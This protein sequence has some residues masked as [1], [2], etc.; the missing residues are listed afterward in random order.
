MIHDR[1]SGLVFLAFCLAY[2][3]LAYD[4]A[5]F[6][7]SEYETFT[8]RTM[9]VGLAAAGS[10][11]SLLIVVL[12]SREMGEPVAMDRDGWLRAGAL[13]VLMVLYG[14]AITRL[15]FVA[16]TSLFLAAG[17]RL[18]GEW[19]WPLIVAIS[20]LVALGFWAILTKL[21]GI[22]LEPGLLL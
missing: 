10:I 13:C 14:L 7:G 16:S 20:G 3:V 17:I 6:P 19:R 11:V 15:G 8:A 12:P 21:L 2:G 1:I 5:L 9:P 4:I 18:L 22:Y